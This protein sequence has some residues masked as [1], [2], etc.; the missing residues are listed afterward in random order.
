MAMVVAWFFAAFWNLISAPLPFVVLEEVRADG[1]Y[2]ALIGLMF[3]AVGLGLLVWALRRTRE[4]TRFGPAPVE[5]DPFPGAIGG[6]VGGTIDLALP[7]DSTAEF[8]VTLTSLRSY[9]SGSGK[10]RSRKEKALWQNDLVAFAEPGPEGTR[11]TFRFDV[12]AGLHESDA[13]DPGD[14]SHAWRLNVRADIP[15]ADFNRDYEIPVYATGAQSAALSASAV[16]RATSR[17]AAAA[18]A[19]VRQQLNPGHD[20]NGRRVHFPAGRNLSLALGGSLVGAIFAGAGY[21]I[22]VHEGERL[23]GGVFGA[24]G[25]LVVAGMIYLAFNSLTVISAGGTLTSVRRLFGLTL[26]RKQMRIADI[27]RLT[28]DSSFQTQAGG[29]HVMHYSV[30]ARDAAGRKMILGEGFRGDGNAAAAVRI[31]ASEFGIRTPAQEPAVAALD[32]IDV[33]AADS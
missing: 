14:S 23:F 11:L 19:A 28:R 10:N 15:G 3:P 22:A 20:M 29:K 33:L 17:R 25:A 16:A 24:I 12:P 13:Q 9:V 2:L 32:E 18:E 1:N 4:W 27:V 6:H 7:Y 26:S 5:M 31:L 21:V 8:E 30:F